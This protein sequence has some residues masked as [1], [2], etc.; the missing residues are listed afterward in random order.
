MCLCVQ[1]AVYIELAGSHADKERDGVSNQLV[2][3]LISA[4]H[5]LDHKMKHAELVLTEGGV[6]LLG[7][8]DTSE[9]VRRAV[10]E[11]SDGEGDM[12]TESDG[13]IAEE[14]SVEETG[15]P[16]THR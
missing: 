11:A 6:P 12:E 1:D 7:G 13:E 3:S 8:G 5:P 16:L 15:E 14:S 10:P 9:G 2:S 4:R